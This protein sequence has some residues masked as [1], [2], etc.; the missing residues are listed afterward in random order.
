MTTPRFSVSRARVAFASLVYERARIDEETPAE[1]ADVDDDD[2][3]AQRDD[4]SGVALRGDLSIASP[5]DLGIAHKLVNLGRKR[6]E[7]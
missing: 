7:N 6:V 3:D 4:A 2:H 5:Q 1:I